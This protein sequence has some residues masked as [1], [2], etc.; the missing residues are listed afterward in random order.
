MA[1]Q[2]YLNLDDSVAQTVND[3]GVSFEAVTLSG[4]AFTFATSAVVLD[5]E[6]SDP[7]DDL[8]T[9]A[10]GGTLK[11]LLI[12]STSPDRVITVKHN[13]GNILTLDG[14]TDI[15]L[16]DP[17]KL[18]LLVYIGSYWVCL[19]LGG[20]GGDPPPAPNSHTWDFTASDGGWALYEAG[21]GIYLNTLGEYV[22]SVGWQTEQ[23]TFGSQRRLQIEQTTSPDLEMTGMDVTVSESVGGLSVTLTLDGVEVATVSDPAPGSGAHTAQLE[24]DHVLCDTIKIYVIDFDDDAVVPEATAYFIGTDPF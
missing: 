7:T 1:N 13:V 10:N 20:G 19:T 22:A 23:H 18:L 16:D 21:A 8:A 3:W 14:A 17:T 12:R 11:M 24:F 6:D 9:I 2:L 4:D 5:T 15:D